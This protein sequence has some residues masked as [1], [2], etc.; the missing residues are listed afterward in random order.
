MSSAV[1]IHWGSKQVQVLIGSLAVLLA[2]RTCRISFKQCQPPHCA[3]ESVLRTN[4]RFPLVCDTL[5]RWCDTR[6]S[7]LHCFACVSH[8]GGQNG[9]V[10]TL[11]EHPQLPPHAFVF[12]REAQ[13]IDKFYVA[14]LSSHA[15]VKH[16]IL[17]WLIATFCIVSYHC[18]IVSLP[19]CFS[20]LVTSM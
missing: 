11:E 15:P 13:T 3:K 6:C 14:F 5:A 9:S 7:N 17:I 16:S 2:Q 19:R 12:N 1:K 20:F 8:V 10:A 18:F 4:Q